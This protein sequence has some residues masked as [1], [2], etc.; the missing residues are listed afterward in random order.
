MFIGRDLYKY[1]EKII[2]IGKEYLIVLYR[3]LSF[4]A[5][6]SR[7]K[8]GEIIISKRDKQCKENKIRIKLQTKKDDN[9]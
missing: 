5:V 2:E 1:T 4:I 7:R 3:I 8:Y 9:D 6:I